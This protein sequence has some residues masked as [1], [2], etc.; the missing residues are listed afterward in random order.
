MG[1]I[2]T[3][4]ANALLA[5]SVKGTA[6]T[7]ATTPVN[8]ALVTANG[9]AT[10]AGTEVSGGSYARQDTT[11][12]AFWG[13]PSAGSITNSLGS[14]S[15]TN[16]PSCTIVGIELWDSHSGTT[17]RRWFGA[18]TATKVVNVGDTVTFA[19]SSITISLT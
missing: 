6:Y 4:E 12:G 1:N 16:M 3:V 9:D 17:I 5:S 10:T 11:T 8:L 18:L 7:A 2:V 13:T 14:V 19:S 15:F